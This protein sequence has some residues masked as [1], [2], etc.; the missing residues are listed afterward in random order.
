MQTRHLT[1]VCS[2]FS[3]CSLR[4]LSPRGVGDVFLRVKLKYFVI[5]MLKM[6]IIVK[7][8]SQRRRKHGCGCV[9]KPANNFLM[10]FFNHPAS[11]PFVKKDLE[12][13]ILL[14]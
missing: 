10:I 5:V 1:I 7:S 12:K 13:L 3:F 14:E 11:I 8:Y 4:I 2:Y 6:Q 9:H